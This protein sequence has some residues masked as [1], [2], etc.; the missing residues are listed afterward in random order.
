MLSMRPALSLPFNDP[1]GNMFHH[2][3][4]ILPDLKEHFEHAYI[5]PSL[6]TRQHADHMRQLQDDDFFVIFPTE[7]ELD[8]GERFSYLYQRTAETAHPD[9]IVHL[10]YLDRLAFAL[11]SE[12]RNR[13]LA[14][15][16]SLT[17]EDMPV[18]FQ[19]SQKAWE[20]HPQ[21]YRALEGLVTI[22][23]HN[24]FGSDLDYCWC[25]FA[26]TARQLREVMPLVKNPDISMV[27]EILYYMRDEVKTR[28][29]DWLAWEDPIVFSRD[30]MEL[31]TERENSL[32]E[33]TKRLN[34]IAPMIETLTRFSSNGR[35]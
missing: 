3:Q 6:A 2:L 17:L 32:A 34:Y 1:D 23:A 14:D 16:D 13:F 27:A 4:L 5:C 28:D 10:C 21:N 30:P 26:A 24:L 29:V 12:Y 31:K 35:K 18:V 7:R 22:V 9:Q 8:V 15:V 33:T 20:T 19:R 25:H 11:E